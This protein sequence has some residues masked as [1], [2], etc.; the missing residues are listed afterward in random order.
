[1]LSLQV[2]SFLNSVSLIIT[3]QSKELHPIWRKFPPIKIDMIVIV[4]CKGWDWRYLQ[5]GEGGLAGE[6]RLGRKCNVTKFDICEIFD[7]NKCRNI[8]V[9]TIYMNEVCSGKIPRMNIL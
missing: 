2:V 9:T 7:K 6:P 4:T 3:N 5:A 8:F 1:M